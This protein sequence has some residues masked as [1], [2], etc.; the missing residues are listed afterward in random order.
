MPGTGQAPEGGRARTPHA[1]DGEEEAAQGEDNAGEEAAPPQRP[2][3][4]QW[5]HARALKKSA[6]APV[7]CLDLALHFS[8]SSVA[9]GRRPWGRQGRPGLCSDFLDIDPLERS[10]YRPAEKGRRREAAR[11][12]DQEKETRR[13]AGDWAAFFYCMEFFFI[14][15]VSQSVSII[16]QMS[17]IIGW[18]I[19]VCMI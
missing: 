11:V 5:E 17:D 16:N 1:R 13:R 6:S 7:L 18:F 12:G 8:R 19:Y 14:N 3:P 9:L 15:S 10:P 2:H 4:R